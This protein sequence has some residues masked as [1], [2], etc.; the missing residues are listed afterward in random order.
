VSR[1]L[2][3]S[4]RADKRLGPPDDRLGLVA[5]LAIVVGGIV[6]T[7][8]FTVPAAIAD[9]GWLS[10]PAFAVVG[11]GSPALALTFVRLVCRTRRLGGPIGSGRGVPALPGRV[12]RVRGSEEMLEIGGVVVNENGWTQVKV[13]RQ[14]RRVRAPRSRGP[15][16][17]CRGA[18][19]SYVVCEAGGLVTGPRRGRFRK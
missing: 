16:G 9:H 2:P 10:V 1:R 14:V 8:I 13:G 5:T 6:G 4:A 3:V 18:S 11:A 17:G 7:G 12:R 19:A 15:I